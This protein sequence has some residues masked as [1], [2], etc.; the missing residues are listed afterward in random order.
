MKLLREVNESVE[1]IVEGADDAP[2]RH[3]LQGVFMESGVKNRN[4]RIYDDS[5][6]RPEVERFNKEIVKENRGFGELGHPSGP[7]INLDRVCT[8]IKEISQN[9]GQYRGKAQIMETPMGQIVKG[10]LEGGA[11]LGVSS[12]ALGSLK[13][14]RDGAMMVQPDLR[15]ITV[16]V[17]ADPSAPNAFVEGIMENKEWV[18]DAAGGW[19][20]MEVAETVKKKIKKMDVRQINEQ[21]VHLFEEFMASVIGKK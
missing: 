6:L 7:T 16:D 15:L 5:V 2:K 8:L 17:V 10:L 13:E 3:Y 20:V 4:G 11:K 21:K 19:K 12:R 14:G 18:Q 1:H 9:G